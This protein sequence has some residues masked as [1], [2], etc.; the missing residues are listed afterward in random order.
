MYAY[1][2][3]SIQLCLLASNSFSFTFLLL[4]TMLA[5]RQTSVS[6]CCIRGRVWRKKAVWEEEG[7]QPLGGKGRE[8]GR[9]QPSVLPTPPTSSPLLQ[10]PG[11]LLLTVITQQHWQANTEP[12]PSALCFIL[13]CKFRFTFCPVQACREFSLFFFCSQSS[14]S[15]CC[16][17]KTGKVEGEG[18]EIG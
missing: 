16:S 2:K 15:A 6:V 7:D 17:S 3:L 8:G 18:G 10:T 5:A 12:Q 11:C 14:H 4:I 13:H 1:L 9:T